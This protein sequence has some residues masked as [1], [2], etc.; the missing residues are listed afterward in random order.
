M[1]KIL[2]MLLPAFASYSQDSGKSC[3]VLLKINAL[4]HREHFRPKPVDD[5]LSVYVFETLMG[6]L[7]TDRN[8]FLKSEYEYLARHRY[9][10]DDYLN[11]GDCSFFDDFSKTY[12]NAL[13]RSRN[14]IEKIQKEKLNY[15]SNDTVRFTKKEFP[16]YVKAEDVAKV[17]TKR[18]KFDILE[19]IAKLSKNFDSLRQHFPALEKISKQKIFETALCKINSRLDSKE[20][21]EKNIRS[22]FYTIFCNYFDPHTS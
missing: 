13:V 21:I 9:K 16:F 5:S 4:V 19:D 2:L 17:Y 18:L 10:L 20:G 12:K 1:K 8:I 15:A 11:R 6:E 22:T 14:A 3:D 7:D